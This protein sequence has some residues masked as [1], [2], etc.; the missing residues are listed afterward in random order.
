[1]KKITIKSKNSNELTETTVTKILSILNEYLHECAEKA[2][3]YDENFSIKVYSKPDSESII[4]RVGR[5]KAYIPEVFNDNF[6]VHICHGD[7]SDANQFL[8]TVDIIRYQFNDTMYLMNRLHNAILSLTC[9]KIDKLTLQVQHNEKYA[10][11]IKYIVKDNKLSS[12]E[13][14]INGALMTAINNLEDNDPILCVFFEYEL[15]NGVKSSFGDKDSIFMNIYKLP[16]G[17][18]LISGSMPSAKFDSG[19]DYSSYYS[20]YENLKQ[21]L[22]MYLKPI[23][24]LKNAMLF[25]ETM[26]VS[27]LFRTIEQYQIVY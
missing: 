22:S 1:M 18:W 23:F 21:I 10:G 6:F 7:E 12:K 17:G 11:S 25:D 26:K 14:F 15:R 19:R 13:K 3:A 4:I 27:F 24:A 8:E 20:D 2:E 9:F 16:D 5:S